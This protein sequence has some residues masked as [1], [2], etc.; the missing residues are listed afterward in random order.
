MRASNTNGLLYF[1]DFE[2][3]AQWRSLCRRGVDLHLAPKEY[4]VLAAL[5]GQAGKAVSRE[6]LLAAV[7]P[8]TSVGDTSLARCVS[9]LRK[10]LGADAI[11]S[12]PKF[13]YRFCLS[14]TTASTERP[15]FADTSVQQPDEIGLSTSGAIPDLT[16]AWRRRWWP[17]IALVAV[18]LMGAASQP[19]SNVLPW[20]KAAT[21]TESQT[22]LMW[23]R[24]DNGV[25]RRRGDADLNHDAATA[26]C[27]ALL[28]GG[29]RDWRLPTIEEL[30]TLHDPAQSTAGFW[31]GYRSVYWHVKGQ[32][33]PTGSETASDL[34]V[35]TDTTPS[36]KEQSYD[37]SFGRRNFDPVQFS[38]DHRALCVRNSR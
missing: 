7:W 11:Q 17:G 26:Y 1:G 4:S 10:Q 21:W 24:Q 31:G 29:H 22:G 32:I 38:A 35:L 37:F 2:F 19:I 9:S 36:G 23:Q 6:A 3:D 28:L 33:T 14:V 34:T 13:G 15:V 8:G 27:S 30:Q 5:V 16:P 12:V 18:A 25:Q 20:T